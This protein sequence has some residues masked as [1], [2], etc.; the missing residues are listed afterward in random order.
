[1]GTVTVEK[2]VAADA[3]A[4]WRVLAD[5]GDVTWIPVAGDVRV[6]GDGPGMRR[7]IS[8]GGDEPVVEK[9]VSIDPDQ[10]SLT[11]EIEQSNPLPV[12]SYVS[13]AV[14]RGDSD[15]IVTW[16]VTYEP[17]GSDEEI[18]QGI[19]LIYTVMAGWLQDAAAR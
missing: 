8:G 14:V 15:A 7:Y 18:R 11:Y 3:A 1:M 4:V 19:D 9:L 6:E 10:R 16:T 12:V 2:K 5:F 17:I 13:Q